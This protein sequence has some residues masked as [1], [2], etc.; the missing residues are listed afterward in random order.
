MPP[1]FVYHLAIDHLPA[2]QQVKQRLTKWL[3]NRPT[4]S[5][6]VEQLTWEANIVAYVNVLYER[7][8]IHGNCKRDTEAPALKTNIPIYGPRFVPPS[9]LHVQK[10]NPVTPLIKPSVLFLKP[11]HVIHPFYYGNL[12]KCPQCGSSEGVSWNS[13]VNTGHRELYGLRQGECALG[14][15]LRCKGCTTGSTMQGSGDSDSDQHCF[16]TTSSAFWRKWEHWN[17]PSTYLYSK[18]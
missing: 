17:I 1:L 4:Q 8:K 3:Q 5:R 11:L 7:T 6:D 14:Y 15:Q 16:A 10:R 12:R 2:S 13:W 9:Y 18:S